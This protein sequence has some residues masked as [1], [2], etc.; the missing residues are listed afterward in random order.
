MGGSLLTE[1]DKLLVFLSAFE[2]SIKKQESILDSLEDFS[3]ESV[4]RNSKLLN[5][6]TTDEYHKL[7]EN[8][9][10]RILDSSI[11]NMQKNGIEIVTIFSDNYPEKLRDLPDRPLI[12]YAKGD[13]SLV[14]KKSVAIVGTRMPSNYGRVITERFT[15]K[16]A[17]SGLVVVSGLCYGID[18]I[19]HKKTLA[20]GGKTI[21]VIGSGFSN[22]YPAS[23][24]SLAQEIAKRGLILS[25]YPP[26]FK[27]KRYTFPRRNRIVAGLSDG[28]LI[29]EAG[30][31]SG[32]IHTK[33]YALE[34]GKDIF[35]VPGNITSPKS[36]LTNDLIKTGQAEC[37]L[38]ADEIIDFY[39]LK[40]SAKQQ[41]IT[42]SFDE[43]AI[44]DALSDGEKDFDF[45]SRKTKIPV[46]ILNSC[47]ATMEI[48][49]LIRKLPGQSYALIGQINFYSILLYLNYALC[50][51]K[52]SFN[53]EI[54]C[55]WSPSKKGYIEKISWKWLRSF[56]YKRS[57]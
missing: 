2:L 8:Y 3:V 22:I 26:S 47:L 21:A 53:F 6:L 50:V 14:N 52:R 24:T 48:R 30:I 36:E 43:K 38:S 13:L 7:L 56:C 34:Y 41:A 23:N 35:A 49:G 37:V 31:K 28:V 33:E 1:R 40:K 55:Y 51:L 57:Y 16:L 46:N 10:K 19:A 27:P 25:E 42:L 54:S 12:L 39:G 17:Q 15:E 9:D 20:V 18:E 5:I 44:V 4:L 11:E 29:V 32:T 45:L